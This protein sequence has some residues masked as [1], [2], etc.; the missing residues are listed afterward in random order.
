MILKHKNGNPYPH[1]IDLNH[2]SEPITVYAVSDDNNNTPLN[3]TWYLASRDGRFS[4]F[5]GS[6]NAPA[7]NG[8]YACGVD[9]NDSTVVQ[10]ASS[11]VVG[12]SVQF[13]PAPEQ[14]NCP[15]VKCVLVAVFGGVQRELIISIS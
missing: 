3:A 8:Q 1:Q 5:P 4:T 9:P 6:L 10:A 7:V 14:V 15:A 11:P 2:N 13:F 12:T